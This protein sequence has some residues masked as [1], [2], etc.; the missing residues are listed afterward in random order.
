LECQ[1]KK[2]EDREVLARLNDIQAAYHKR[3]HSLK[4]SGASRD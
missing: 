3:H 1:D 2:E 4:P